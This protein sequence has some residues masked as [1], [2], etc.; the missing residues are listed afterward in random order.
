MKNSSF[1]F[2]RGHFS[3][4]KI[5][6]MTPIPIAQVFNRTDRFPEFFFP[7]AD[8]VEFFLELSWLGLPT[9]NKMFAKL[10]VKHEDEEWGYLFH[11]LTKDVQSITHFTRQMIHAVGPSC[12]TSLEPQ[13]D[14]LIEQEESFASRATIYISAIAPMKLMI[15]LVLETP[16]E[17]CGRTG[18]YFQDFKSFRK[19]S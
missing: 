9:S 15:E 2:L 16:A 17:F 3:Y 10:H 11:E 4:Q 7:L 1:N 12:S 5:L 13:D 19:R 8:G 6:P 14:I 18:V